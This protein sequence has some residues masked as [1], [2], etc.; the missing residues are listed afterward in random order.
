MT[1]DRLASL[2]FVLGT[3][4]LAGLTACR[5]GEP[6][7]SAVAPA[8]ITRWTCAMH[9]TYLSD[10][11]GQCP[12]CN[13]D[14]VPVEPAA[15]PAAAPTA[16]EPGERQVAFYRSPMD[17]AITSPVPAKD[18][19]GMEF[20]PVYA[21][22]LTGGQA[23]SAV[24]GRAAVELAAPAQ[25]RL[26]V[27][28][29]VAA[30]QRLSRTIRA[31]GAV[32]PDER[33]LYRVQSKISGWVERLDANAT[34][35]WVR[36][37]QSL[38]AVYS[39]EL[40]AGQEE[41]LLARRNAERFLASDLPEVRR[42]GEDLVA[43]ARRRLALLDVPATFL[44][45]LEQ[46]GVPKRTVEL[47]AP[48]SGTVIEKSVVA[49]QQ[50]TPGMELLTLADL[51]Q[52]W[53]DAEVPEQDARYVGVGTPATLGL[54]YDAATA[55]RTKVAFVYPSIDTATRSLRLR[56]EVANPG[57]VFKPGMFVDVELAIDLGTGVVVPDSAVL[58]S[59][60]R[61]LAY[62]ETAPGH[63]EPRQVSVR[64]RGDGKAL[65]ADG[66]RAGEKVA[67]RANFL[68]DG[69]SRLRESFNQ[70]GSLPGARP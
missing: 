14:L 24:E 9:P 63:F 41:Y 25:E 21:D 20:V 46:D 4:M 54:A 55:R 15:A 5:S 65:L 52:I 26:G 17:P 32:T 49:G 8:K 58:D 28:I 13:M 30:T 59:G 19:M 62:V 67:V 1:H 16:G 64:W 7:E 22:E 53:V 35:Q 27:A 37:G 57:Q 48:A 50:I 44:A 47:L 56:F 43:A 34:G 36:K 2:V 23:P 40:L 39:P 31:V 29:A 6:A 18:E 61:Q 10:R 66:V 3:T 45:Q 38:M 70:A 12:I 11:P 42:G 51:S 60:S 33:R 68:L 69:E